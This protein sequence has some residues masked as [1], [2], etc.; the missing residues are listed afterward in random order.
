GSWVWQLGTLKLRPG[1]RI[2][3]YLRATDNDAVGGAK[4]GQSRTQTLA[5]FSEA[6]HRRELIAKVEEAWE[7][8]VLALGDRIAPRQ[9]PRAVRREERVEAGAPADEQVLQVGTTLA[10]VAAE[11]RKDE[12]APQELTGA[13]VNISRNVL[14]TSRITRAVRTRARSGQRN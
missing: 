13:L 11:L 3:Y 2:T 9:G 12:N 6:E 5:V 7:N 14:E 8:M 1:D 4:Q 10:D